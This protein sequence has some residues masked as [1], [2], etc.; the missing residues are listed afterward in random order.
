M[1]N[2]YKHR[3]NYRVDRLFSMELCRASTIANPMFLDNI[4]DIGMLPRDLSRVIYETPCGSGAGMLMHPDGVCKMFGSHHEHANPPMEL[5]L[6]F[7]ATLSAFCVNDDNGNYTLSTLNPSGGHTSMNP[8]IDPSYPPVTPSEIIAATSPSHI[9]QS[10]AVDNDV[11]DERVPYALVIGSIAGVLVCLLCILPVIIW[12]KMKKMELGSS[13]SVK[14]DEVSIEP[15]DVVQENMDS[16]RSP[17]PSEHNPNIGEQDYVDEE[18]ERKINDIF[19]H[20]SNFSI[21]NNDEVVGD[22]ET[23]GN[24][25]ETLGNNHKT[26]Y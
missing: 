7:D 4:T 3:I 26:I 14:V 2:R 24:D 18:N 21:G 15:K 8:S 20:V 16:K 5:Y 10:A 6:G 13:V 11:N 17:P 23:V 9:D 19:C 25:E 22:D 12:K 1:D